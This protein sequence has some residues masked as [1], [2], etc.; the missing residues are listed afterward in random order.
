MPTATVVLVGTLDT[1]GAEYGFLRDRLR[2]AGLATVVVDVGTSGDAQIAPDITREEVAAESQ[3]DLGSLSGLPDRG[4]AVG[5]MTHAAAR[6]VRRLYDHGRCD[7]VIA[8]GGSGNTA[9]ATAAMRALPLFVPKVMVSTMAASDTSRYLGASDIVMIPAVCDVAGMNQVSATVLARAAATVAVLIRTPRA[10]ASGRTVIAASMFGVTTPAVTAARR[11]LTDQG[12]EVVTFHATG[13]GGRAMEELISSGVAGGTLDITT[14][15][16]ADELVGGNLSAGPDRLTA[17]GRA[18]VPQVVSLGALDMVN[19]GPLDTVPQQFRGRRL[20]RHNP[21]ITLMRTSPAEC[22][23]LGAII[24]ERLSSARGRTALFIPLRGMSQISTP[25]G[26]FFDRQ[27]DDALIDA[28]RSSVA[29]SVELHEID[30]DI[31]DPEFA[32][33]MAR[34][35]HGLLEAPC[36]S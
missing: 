29:A 15:E 35:L 33:A 25:D 28:I 8:A 32:V 20:L 11:W 23:Q 24:S 34:R 31:N 19:F 17:A 14:T 9:I 13:S 30:T 22:A 3:I 21:D 1:K 6:F 5:A 26:P 18:G 16:L 10:A 36:E 2:E 7:A 27:A 4:A 12:Y